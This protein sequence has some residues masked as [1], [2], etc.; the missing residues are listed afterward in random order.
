MDYSCAA[1]VVVENNKDANNLAFVYNDITNT[2][3][4]GSVISYIICD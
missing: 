3:I 4:K 1:F 2:K